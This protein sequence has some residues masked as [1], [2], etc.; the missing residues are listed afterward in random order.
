MSL[1]TILLNKQEIEERQTRKSVSETVRKNKPIY[2]QLP[3]Q[4]LNMDTHIKIQKEIDKHNLIN[5]IFMFKENDINLKSILNNLI[6]VINEEINKKDKDFIYCVNGSASW[7][8]S[9]ESLYINNVLSEYEKSA[10]HDTTK[11]IN[12]FNLNKR[13]ISQDYIFDLIDEYI[14]K[15]QIISLIETKI[16]DVYLIKNGG[17]GLL[18]IFLTDEDKDHFTYGIEIEKKKEKEKEKEN[19]I[20]NISLIIKNESTL[21]IIYTY[22]LISFILNFNDRI[23]ATNFDKLLIKEEFNYLN[24]YGIYLFNYLSKANRIKVRNDYDIYT[25]RDFIYD[26]Y[27]LL[28]S[29]IPESVRSEPYIDTYKLKILNDIKNLYILIFGTIPKYSNDYKYFKYLIVNINK[30]IFK[31]NK[32]FNELENDIRYYI[33]QIFRPY[34]NF[35]I[36]KINEELQSENLSQLFI[37]GG[38]ACR[39]YENNLSKT[40]DIDTKLYLNSNDELMV[41]EQIIVKNISFLL[42]FLIINREI[43]LE[44]GLLKNYL[45]SKGYNTSIDSENNLICIYESNGIKYSLIYYFNDEDSSFFRFRHTLYPKFPVDLYASDFQIKTSY[46]IENMGRTRKGDVMFEDNNLTFD[47][48]YLDISVD[49]PKERNPK[50]EDMK[51]YISNYSILSNDLPIS[52]LLFLINDLID[53]YNNDESSIMRFI[54][55]KNIKDYNRFIDLVKI[56][57]AKLFIEERNKEHPTDLNLKILKE[58]YFKDLKFVNES[59]RRTIIN[60]QDANKKNREE[61]LDISITDS[62]MLINEQ[63]SKFANYLIKKYID[64]REEKI[65]RIIFNFNMFDNFNKELMKSTK[66][67]K[68]RSIIQKPS[69]KK[70]GTLEEELIMEEEI[71]D[72]LYNEEKEEEPIEISKKEQIIDILLK[73][74]NQEL[75]ELQ[76][77]LIGKNSNNIQLIKNF[78]NKNII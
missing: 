27:I 75:K 37:V 53:T 10:I 19:N 74:E 52:K 2:S 29:N 61:V 28:D 57:K 46:K 17:I 42:S 56:E 59:I 1:R 5:N 77:I 41:A 72:N 25:V 33:I 34:I 8:K 78:L 49:I 36:K 68:S 24:I 45:D 20:Y 55:G 21:K 67:T 73:N 18:N 39:R 66:S 7:Y 43:V 15:N 35:I 4:L 58:N 65:E 6:T 38:D 76:K 60:Y 31:T 23:S 14:E 30:L 70:G 40:E 13:K 16:I 22:N 50:Y 62:D 32:K 47:M 44:L 9:L 71:K 12:Y 11:E 26:K 64:K 48:A 51:K 3:K 69:A 63:L 54:N